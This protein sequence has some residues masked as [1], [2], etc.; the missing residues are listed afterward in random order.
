LTGGNFS[1]IVQ[2]VMVVGTLAIGQTIVILTGGIDLSAGW[3]MALTGIIM[4]TLAVNFGLPPLLAIALGLLL[5]VGLGI[6]NGLLVTI[7]R[8]P[9]FIVTLGTFSIAQALT[10]IISN[11]QTVTNVPVEMTAL[12]NTFKVFNTQITYGSVLM[13]VLF[14]LVWFILQYTTLG[15]Q[16]YAVGDNPEAARLAGINTTK[17]LLG[18]YSSA[19]LLY[20]IGALLLVGRTSV[21]DPNAGG[22]AAM[23]SITAVVL[24]GTSLMGGRGNLLGTL[25]GAMIIGV[26]VNGLTLMGVPSIY[27][28]LITGILV[29]LAVSVDVLSHR[30][31]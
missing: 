12:G 14:V 6:L 15:R 7:I 30:G 3:F 10:L 28:L 2:Q 5:C 1:L 23:S 24:G 8:L 18:V 16:I 27:Q 26:F 25:V 21:G 17:V 19:A 29:I 20:G 11:A 22:D 31:K 4:T 9:P 13:L